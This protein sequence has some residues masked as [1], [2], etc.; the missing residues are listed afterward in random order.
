[1]KIQAMQ[2]ANIAA[3]GYRIA[4]AVTVVTVTQFKAHC[5]SLMER[6]RKTRKPVLIAKHGRAIAQL[7]PAPE[8]DTSPGRTLRGGVSRMAT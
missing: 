5:L 4:K 6:L 8:E 2:V 1:V 7:V 3:A